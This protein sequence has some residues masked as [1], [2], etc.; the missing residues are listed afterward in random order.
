[1]YLHLC[2]VVN[3]SS[4]ETILEV[5]H[6]HSLPQYVACQLP[7]S[8]AANLHAHAQTK[9]CLTHT[10]IGNHGR[11][12]VEVVQNGFIHAQNQLCVVLSHCVFSFMHDVS[13]IA[14]L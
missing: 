7:T 2:L 14:I 13:S 10:V 8:A 3:E 5:H 9:P 11:L 4:Q 6:A 12:I 1:M